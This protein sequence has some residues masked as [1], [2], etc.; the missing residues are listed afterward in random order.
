M[1]PEGHR[2]ISATQAEIVNRQIR[3]NSDWAFVIL[4]EG[5]KICQRCYEALPNVLDDSF[6]LEAMDIASEDEMEKIDSPCREE[7]IL[8]KQAAKEELNAVFQLLNMEKIR[9]ER[10]FFC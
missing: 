2:F 1:H 6:D 10:V 3:C 9:D 7:S 4:K 8:A 5:D